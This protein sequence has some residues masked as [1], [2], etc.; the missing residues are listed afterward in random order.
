MLFDTHMHTTFSTDSTMKIEDAIR[1]GQEQ[2][3]GI[4]ITEHM[5]LGYPD[6]NAFQFDVDEYLTTYSKFRRDDVLL[7]IEIGMRND[8]LQ[9]NRDLVRQVEVDFVIGSIHVIDNIDIYH[10]SF[11][12]SHTKQYVYSRYF[13]AMLEC[14]KCYDFI[15]SLGHIDYIARYARFSDPEI[16]YDEFAEAIDAVLK[17]VVEQEKALEINTRR[18]TDQKSIDLLMPIYK[19]FAE[20]GGKLV[21]VGS[22]AHKPADIGRGLADGMALAAACG[23]K[24]VYF[25][26]RQAYYVK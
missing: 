26:E 22:D 24:A 4:I 15:D 19:R 7:G 20:L 17:I 1:K 8:C 14:M 9:D 5:D 2:S 3:I 10:E 18:I 11:Y 6:S 12:C 21:T 16:Y 23:L 13:E 25:K